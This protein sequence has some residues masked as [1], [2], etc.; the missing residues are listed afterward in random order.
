[1]RRAIH[2]EHARQIECLERGEKLIQSTRRWDDDRGETT[3]MRTKEDAHDYR[4]F[5][6]P[7]LLP[8]HTA[9]IVEKVRGQVPE[10]PH[11][12][13]ARFEEAYGCSAYDAGVLA[14][15]QALAGYFEEAIA[16][17]PELPAKKIANWVINA[18]LGAL[19][20]AGMSLADCPVTP[21]AL[22][23]LVGTI[24]SGKI[25]A[26]QGKD[27]FAE[28]MASGRSA[29]EIIKEKGFE[30]VSDTGEL[31]AMVD[32]IIAGNPDRV[33]EVKSGNA[34]ALNW[35]TGQVMKASKGKANPKIVTE[36]LQ[37]KLQG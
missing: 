13:R 27:V 16:G 22:A 12:K 9:E 19:N 17:A 29:A 34:K 3:L 5:P 6:D 11:Q 33:A 4:Y 24:E 7:D 23:A 36:L 30:Q 15:E 32:E 18:L 37:G 10:L 25:S 14:S 28:M 2:F 8:L 20:D 35:F 26:N 21:A 1:M 31:E